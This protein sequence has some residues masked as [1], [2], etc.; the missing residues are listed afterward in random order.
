MGSLPLPKYHQIYLVLRQK[1]DEG[2][3]DDGVPPEKELAQQFGVGRVTVRRA[4]EQLVN[5]N[6][7]VRE[8][9]RGTWPAPRAEQLETASQGDNVN[10]RLAGL[11]N[12]IVQ[13]SRRTTVKVLE[14]S[15]IRASPMLAQALQVAEGE[16]VR[17]IVRTRS[18]SA[19]PV[20]FITTHLPEERAARLTR[21]DVARKPVL[22]L[23]EESGVEW[24]RVRQTISA[25]QADAT[26]AA[27]LD[28]SIGAALLSVRRLVYD[29]SD[30][31][32]QLLH[33]LYR[34]DRYEYQME[35]TQFG[36]IE[37]RV[38]EGEISP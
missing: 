13:A 30:R 35:L 31:P 36:D 6:L 2:L 10:L 9:G 14:W 25:S 5:E 37:A 3:Y 19:G 26:V 21:A 22:Q 12:N 23:L 11:L 20:S 24:G 34:P 17:K 29:S 8:A 32:V 33:G 15:V 27:E 38:S 7:I 1:L 16:P 28:V 4:L 18:S